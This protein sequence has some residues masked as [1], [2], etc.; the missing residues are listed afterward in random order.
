MLCD[1]CWICSTSTL[2]RQKERVQLEAAKPHTQRSRRRVDDET[3]TSQDSIAVADA[4]FSK[5]NVAPGA[6][7]L[8]GR[9]GSGSRAQSLSKTQDSADGELVSK[10]QAADQPQDYAEKARLQDPGASREAV[11]KAKDLAVSRGGS[12]VDAVP[13]P[14]DSIENGTPVLGPAM[15]GVPQHL[16]GS[17]LTYSM[18]DATG[19]LLSREFLSSEFLSS[20]F[21]AASRI[22]SF[23][24]EVAPLWASHAESRRGS[25]ISALSEVEPSWG[26][27]RRGSVASQFPSMQE[28]PTIAETNDDSGYKS[29]VVPVDAQSK[30][31]ATAKAEA[32]ASP[33]SGKKANHSRSPL[34]SPSPKYTKDTKAALDSPPSSPSPGMVAKGHWLGGGGL[35][36]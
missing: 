15:L 14:E 28:L 10:A 4:A 5:H 31:L 17:N 35:K 1:S 32:N 8:E 33:S 11:S 12:T 6:R 7:N 3:E 27:D 21:D 18:S 13:K 30:L 26:D 9:C 23:L 20:E 2:G 25:V 29:G 34:H 36:S 24:S 22:D 16:M 19:P